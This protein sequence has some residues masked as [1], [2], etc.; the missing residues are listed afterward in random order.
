[1]ENID[2]L[3]WLKILIPVLALVL[4]LAIHY[5]DKRKFRNDMNKRNDSRKSRLD[6]LNDRV[7]L[8]EQR[9]DRLVAYLEG[10]RNSERNKSANSVAHV[11]TTL[12]SDNIKNS[13][14]VD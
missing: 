1:M 3:T 10:E 11:P 12:S 14:T 6:K 2:W 13:K 8:M 5:S 4:I 7:N 9:F